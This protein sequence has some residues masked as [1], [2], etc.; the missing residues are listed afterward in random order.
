MNHKKAVL[1][2][3]VTAFFGVE[4]NPTARAIEIGGRGRSFTT[5]NVSPDVE[6][7]AVNVL[8]NG[9]FGITCKL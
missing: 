5:N 1:S 4:N 8:N 3:D 6:G 2:E 7:S 9:K